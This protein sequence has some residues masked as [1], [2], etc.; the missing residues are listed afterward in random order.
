MLNSFFITVAAISLFTLQAVANIVVNP[1][2]LIQEPT[3]PNADEMVAQRGSRAIGIFAVVLVVVNFILDPTSDIINPQSIALVTTL[4]SAGFLMVAFSLEVIGGLNVFLFKV[5]EDSLTY[6]GL[7]L[8]TGLYFVLDEV[9]APSI[10]TILVLAFLIL[11]WSIWI[12]Y[13]F[14]YIVNIQSMEWE[15]I[16]YS[17]CQATRQAIARHVR[18]IILIL[19]SII[20]SIVVSWL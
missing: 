1:Y 14:D 13:K 8:F 10:L 17:R 5:Q 2:A 3:S 11:S 19:S 15:A 12:I 4:I 18:L 6:A 16:D 20:V 7:L 9:D